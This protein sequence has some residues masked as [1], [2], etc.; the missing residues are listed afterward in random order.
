MF[1]EKGSVHLLIKHLILFTSRL[2]PQFKV[3]LSNQPILGFMA[4]K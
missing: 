2:S 4:V 1:H 3:S